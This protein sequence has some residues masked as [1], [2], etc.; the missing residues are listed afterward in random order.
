MSIGA[1]ALTGALLLAPAVF[2]NNE[3]DNHDNEREGKMER[4]REVRA[5]GSTLE[6]HFFDD[7]NVLV[8]G[9]KVTGI[10]GSVVNASN[11]WGSVTL[12]WAVK[13]DQ[14]TNIVRRAG[15]N[16]SLSE[17]SVGDIVSF[18][19]MLDT[20]IVSPLTVNAKVLKDW[21]IQKIRAAFSGTVRSV[22]ASTT[23][24]MLTH[25]S[26]GDVNVLVASSTVITKGSASATF[27]DIVVGARV[28]VRGLLN[29]VL[30]TLASDEVKIRIPEP[31]PKGHIKT[32]LE[33]TLTSFA[34][35]TAPTSFVLHAGSRDYT[36][37]VDGSTSVLNSLWLRTPLSN[38]HVG[39]RVRV[40]GTVN[41]D[42]T[43]DATVVRDTSI[44]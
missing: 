3:N 2:A 10:S 14:T 27:G 29:T 18:Q 42:L 40:Y 33:G 17:I 4:M 7:G 5:A 36:V 9:A 28:S 6:V 20:G 44:R 11:V 34:S 37:R 39:D 35:T 13:T 21:S 38:F 25:E 23:S 22:S 43:V 41:A 31:S 26:R 1:A 16:S 19:G 30:N 8:R 32:T 15:G 24:F 12:N